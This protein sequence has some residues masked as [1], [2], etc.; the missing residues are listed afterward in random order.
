MTPTVSQYSDA[1]LDDMEAQYLATL[2]PTVS[3]AY[4]E[5]LEPQHNPAKT[6]LKTA[7]EKLA[8]LTDED[9]SSGPGWRNIAVPKP[10][11]VSCGPDDRSRILTLVAPVSSGDAGTHKWIVLAQ[12]PDDERGIAEFDFEADAE[13]LLRG[14][15]QP[16]A[17]APTDGT[18]VKV[19]AAPYE[20]LPG[21]Q[22]VAAYHPDGGW[23]VCELRT[24]THWQPLGPDPI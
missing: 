1:E 13:T 6:S 15:W 9:L 17:T 2:E 12:T 18:P 7:L 8:A 10:R 20:D 21:F 16:I 3:R 4:R 24:V 19:Y 11:P 22:A 5:S 23:C 14:E